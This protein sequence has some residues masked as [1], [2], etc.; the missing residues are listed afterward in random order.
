M[1]QPNV[2]I[3]G[4]PAVKDFSKASPDYAKHML[5]HAQRVMEGRLAYFTFE[6]NDW[7]CVG[8]PRCQ[9]YSIP[10][11][12]ETL[13]WAMCYHGTPLRDDDVMVKGRPDIHYR[14]ALD[15]PPLARF[16]QSVPQSMIWMRKFKAR[17]SGADDPTD[18]VIFGG[19]LGMEAW[20]D[21]FSFTL[22]ECG[23]VKS[24]WL[25]IPG[26]RH[27]LI[28]PKRFHFC[29]VRHTGIMMD[30]TKACNTQPYP[31]SHPSITIHEVT[32]PS[33]KTDITEGFQCFTRLVSG[34]P[35]SGTTRA[36]LM[37]PAIVG[38]G[39][40]ENDGPFPWGGDERKRGAYN[41]QDCETGNI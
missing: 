14:E 3:S 32:P 18:Q 5:T 37:W 34:S 23:V 26:V 2:D 21:Y 17:W 9:R 12:L 31:G 39:V 7:N 1:R 16:V 33:P 24:N 29:M 15:F 6:R 25:G 41:K 35:P 19:K 20:I 22:R 27:R 40:C 28:E 11:V 8:G 38:Q 4:D 10:L 36:S 13:R 30:S